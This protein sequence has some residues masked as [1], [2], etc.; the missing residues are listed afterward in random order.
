MA[1]AQSEPGALPKGE[2]GGMPLEKNFTGTD[3]GGGKWGIY[4]DT[5]ITSIPRGEGIADC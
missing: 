4:E 5:G 3:G 2:G 1:G